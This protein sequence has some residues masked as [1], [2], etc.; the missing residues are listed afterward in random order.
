MSDEGF[1]S[2]MRNY[3]WG[4]GRGWGCKGPCRLDRDG[5]IPIIY[6]L[7]H[8]TTNVTGARLIRTTMSQL[9]DRIGITAEMHIAT[10][11]VSERAKCF[12]VLNYRF[13]HR[14]VIIQ[15]F[16]NRYVIRRHSPD[17]QYIFVGHIY[18]YL[19][20]DT[21]LS[22]RVHVH[23]PSFDKSQFHLSRTVR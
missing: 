19:L 10:G 18:L 16:N 17:L 13:W 20:S 3:S 4:C 22:I 5:F 21:T 1:C 8:E 2:Y 15:L 7:L 9:R 11:A 12:H 6:I 14:D 23:D